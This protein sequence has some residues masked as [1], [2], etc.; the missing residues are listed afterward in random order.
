MRLQKGKDIDAP[1]L[2]SGKI[3]PVNRY[4]VKVIDLICQ[5]EHFNIYRGENAQ[6][7][8]VCLK[9][10][11]YRSE[12]KE[13]FASAM[14]YVSVRR[15]AL[16]EEQKFLSR[17]Y[18]CMPEPLGIIILE[19]DTPEDTKL[20][21][22]SPQWEELRM[23]EPI[24]IQEF[25]DSRPISEIINIAKNYSLIKR[26]EIFQKIV[27]F[28]RYVHQQG[29][30]IQNLTPDQI[31]MNPYNDTN[32]YFVGLHHTCIIQDGKVDK[33]HPAYKDV[34][35]PCL[36][37]E[38]LQPGH[39]YDY[40]ID[41][42][43]LGLV[44]YYLLSGLN[45]AKDTWWLKEN[46]F[47]PIKTEIIPLRKVFRAYFPTQ[48]WIL[49]L[50]IELL[51]PFPEQRI[52]DI[53]TLASYLQFPFQEKVDFIIKE[54]TSET[55]DLHINSFPSNA[56][57]LC[58]RIE[59][60]GNPKI[61][62]REFPLGTTITLPE[63]RMGKIVCGV[64]TLDSQGNLSGWQFQT[65]T[66]KSKLNFIQKMDLQPNKFG[67]LWDGPEQPHHVSI[68]AFDSHNN[69]IFLGEYTNNEA[70]LPPDDVTLNFYE[71]Y[72]IECTP[73]YVYENGFLSGEVYE[74][75]WKFFPP[76]PDPIVEYIPEGV[77]VSMI[78]TP[79]Q[80]K[81]MDSIEVI[82]NGMEIETKQS[83]IELSKQEI[84]L[85]Y[86]I[87]EEL[88]FSEAHTVCFQM[89]FPNIGWK[90]GNSVPI[91]MPL[92]SIEKLELIE[93]TAGA[94]NLQWQKIKHPLFDSYEISYNNQKVTRI[95]DNH[96][97]FICPWSNIEEQKD[98]L[99]EI[100][101]VFMDCGKEIIS[102]PTSILYPSPS[103]E[104]ILQDKILCLVSPFS[105][106]LSIDKNLPMPLQGNLILTLERTDEAQQTISIMKSKFSQDMRMVDPGIAPSKVYTYCIRLE[107]SKTILWQ[108]VVTI[109]Q[110]EI[111]AQL[112]YVGYEALVWEIHVEENTAS[113]LQGKIEIIQETEGKETVQ[114]FK[115]NQDDEVYFF[116]DK[117][118]IPGNRYKYTL[119]ANLGKELYTYDM[120]EVNTKEYILE[121]QVEV[122]YNRATITWNPSIAGL[123]ESIEIHDRKGRHI[124]TTKADTITLEN[125]EPDRNYE[126]PL[127]YHYS[128]NC[129]KEGK[130]IY[131]RTLP[132]QIPAEAFD[133]GMDYFRL[134]WD[135]PDAGVARRIREFYL[136]ISE[137]VGKHILN[138]TT[139]S[140]HLK[141]L[142]PGTTYKW[143]I[144]AR[145]KSGT[146]V[147]LA[148]GE[149]LTGLPMFMSNIEVGLVHHLCW[150]FTPSPAIDKIDVYRNDV[151]IGQTTD[152]EMYDSDFKGANEI[153]YKF[154]YVLK[155]DRRVLADEKTI[156][157]LTMANL[158][159]ALQIHSCI[160]GI[161]W[162]FSN[163]RNFKFFKYIELYQ[164]ETML[165]KQGAHV[166]SLIFEDF[167]KENPENNKFI[168]LN[169]EAKNYSLAIVGVAPTTKKCKKK[170]TLNIKGIHCSYPD[171]PANFDVYSEHCCIFFEW[172]EM[173]TD[174]LRQ[175][176]IRREND[177]TVL[178]Q[179]GNQATI[180]C[181]D[182][183]GVGLQV[184]STYSYTIEM[185]YSNFYTTKTIDITLDIFDPIH[186][187][188]QTT[189]IDDVLQI[190]WDNTKTTSISN[191]GWQ[192]TKSFSH[193]FQRPI[194][195]EFSAG[196][197]MIPLPSTKDFSYQLI[198]HDQY[199][200]TF[201]TEPQVITAEDRI[202]MNTMNHSDDD[203]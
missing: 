72:I 52:P 92:P 86:L 172:D 26:M 197:L 81:M 130:V 153:N 115:W 70:I 35:A 126:F 167:G 148:Q 137:N 1:V 2:I 179:G 168:G 134:R 188:F 82:H 39:N 54:A 133:I 183:D 14:D 80:E 202:A 166:P 55:I 193:F 186:L 157:P 69:S 143:N 171:L 163:I 190:T 62:Y 119:K 102:N 65:T 75:A 144:M 131:F 33:K 140:V 42:Y 13:Q 103:I 60:I 180:F 49:D 10:I 91:N 127:I 37:G 192:R 23:Q 139:R 124:S 40:R 161:K 18:P 53:D 189:I 145:L 6:G 100:S 162:D 85:Q 46:D 90:R 173:E 178:Y 136:D 181:D 151:S 184:G 176:T 4:Q 164:D 191:I 22:K 56:Q 199:G 95:R 112:Q 165:Y 196:T 45:P 101:A 141:Q 158:F 201:I 109:P 63:R 113:C 187:N 182:N 89:F 5:G 34:L 174:L 150:N 138:K 32:V 142:Y 31:L 155:D 159:S 94:C 198:F 106:Q 38:L 25:F 24:F 77:Q 74:Q 170:W 194:W 19:N 135:V 68:T 64:A 48:L 7:M 17:A 8:S 20:F 152:N 98:T 12:K 11:R 169:D 149:T 28:C 111:S 129:A 87:E 177:G 99:I 203:L 108:K 67:I 122:F 118:L 96:Y 58:V 21:R 146:I 79:D 175:I 61:F 76:I 83:R 123:L 154:Y 57:K 47:F 147:S 51:E 160:G 78:V 73:Y 84:K 29:Y 16:L 3:S 116:E 110:V 43:Q 200:H 107:P 156:K 15:A 128:A 36:P 120:G 104:N 59:T 50:L 44:L 114:S 93:K 30:I 9:A 88:S 125:L 66:I 71:P 117:N 195:T 132:Y 185:F 27:N 41:L 105:V 97:L 121:E